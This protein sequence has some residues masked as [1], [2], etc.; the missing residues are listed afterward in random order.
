MGRPRAFKGELVIYRTAVGRG[1]ETTSVR[2]AG[3]YTFCLLKAVETLSLGGSVWVKQPVH[4]TS[5]LTAEA[6]AGVRLVDSPLVDGKYEKEGTS[7]QEPEMAQPFFGGY[8]F[9]ETVGLWLESGREP[10]AALLSPFISTEGF[11]FTPTEFI[12]LR[13][14]LQ[15]A[16]RRYERLPGVSRGL[17]DL[18]TGFF[19]HRSLE[20]SQE[21]IS[22]H[23][24]EYLTTGDKLHRDFLLAINLHARSAAVSRR[25]EIHD[26]T[27]T[28]GAL[29]EELNA[30]KELSGRSRRKAFQQL[31]MGWQAYQEK[32]NAV[33]KEA[34]IEEEDT[35]VNTL[36]IESSRLK[37]T[38]QNLPRE[39]QA[40]G[41]S[42][43]ALTVDPRHGNAQTLKSLAARL[44]ELVSSINE[45]GLYQ[46]PVGGADAATTPRQL[47]Q[48]ES[49]LDQLRNTR[50]HLAELPLFYE[51]RH[52][53]YAQPAHLR[54]LLAPLLDLPT[55]E[56]EHAFTSW[57]FERCLE[58]EEQPRRHHT[59]TGDLAEQFTAWES[60]E[61][62]GD[63]KA[64]TPGE[65]L[66]LLNT[67]DDWPAVTRPEDLLISLTGKD[68]LPANGN[69]QRLRIAP[70]QDV[71]AVHFAVAGFR[72]P[73]LLFTQ[74][75]LPQAPPR[76]RVNHVDVAPVS[77]FKDR[78][79]LQAGGA[80]GWLPL[81]E[82]DGGP[83][84]ILNCYLPS[85]LSTRDAAA[86][87]ERWEELINTVPEIVFFHTWSSDAITQALLSDGFTAEFLCAALLRAAEAASFEPFDQEALVALGHEVRLRCGLTTPTPHPLAEG[88]GQ[89]LRVRL[90]RHFFEEHLPWRDT[91][92][93]LVVIAPDGKKT[94]LLP[95][96]RLPGF[97]DELSE[98]RRQA[99]LTKAGFGVIGLPAARIWVNAEETLEEIVVKLGGEDTAH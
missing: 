80:S 52:F 57:Y 95:D 12:D 98:A 64:V 43:S 22:A 93:P 72:E 29:R 27:K 59:E 82:W 13:E 36:N 51:R 62:A 30:A 44:K 55:S 9:S 60:G 25:T 96:G 54:R 63:F 65:Q 85:E 33:K 71:N 39:L 76:W 66:H 10:A 15:R 35:F 78:L 48:L 16:I 74:A 50:H 70:L 99:E 37:G 90:P 2:G 20:E 87:L 41:L 97:A 11:S 58:R 81:A 38:Q 67:T 23:L 84:D 19:R 69:S 68:D 77:A 32:Y 47:Q 73:S 45:A 14:R 34:A 3:K 24:T 1:A 83:A 6:L 4:G 89:L 61:L 7:S 91:F 88:F 53:W 92:L 56:W 42:L 40:A 21:F 5:E 49:L 26:A 8:S 17:E 86:F 46:L 28:L 75:F 94:V 31:A 18:N 79:L